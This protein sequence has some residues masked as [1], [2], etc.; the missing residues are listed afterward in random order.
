MQSDRTLRKWYRHINRRY[1]DGACSNSVLV[2]WAD[3]TE[4]VDPCC[5][6]AQPADGRHKYQIVIN[7]A[8][9]PTASAWLSTLAHE[10][11]HIATELQ[12]SHGPAFERWREYI[13]HRGIFRK[14]ALHKHITIF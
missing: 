8:K 10:M 13:A 1:F 9:N 3:E 7:R 4:E 14:H 12:D 11:I 5:A 6:W 2:R